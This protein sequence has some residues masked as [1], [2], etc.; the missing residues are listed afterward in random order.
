MRIENY[1]W[2]TILLLLLASL[3]VSACQNTK[4]EGAAEEESCEKEAVIETVEVEERD[5]AYY[6]IVSG[7]HTDACTETDAITQE[8]VGDTIYVTVC[9]TRPK[10][11]LCAQ[12]LAPFEEEILLN[13]QGLAPGEFTVDAN[14]TTATFSIP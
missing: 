1:T 8:M 14:G 3:M 2:A 4:T 12:V 11:M 10:D 9:T 13:T 7:T 5:D 6:A